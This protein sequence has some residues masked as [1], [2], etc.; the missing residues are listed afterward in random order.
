MPVSKL[1]D[2]EETPQHKGAIGRTLSCVSCGL[3][4]HAISPRMPPH[5]AGAKKLMLIG[6]GPG[7]TED[8]LGKP[9]QGKAGRT[10]RD[11][12]SDLGVKVDTDCVGLNAVNCRPPGNRAPTPHES[13]CCRARIVSPALVEHRPRVVLLLG[14][15]AVA[16]VIGSIYPDADER[17]GKWRGMTIPAPELGCW[18]CPTFHPSYVLREDRRPEI[19]TIWEQDLREAVSRLRVQVPPVENLHDCVTILRTDDEVVEALAR[20]RRRGSPASFDYETTGLRALV[21]ELVCASFAQSEARAY[22]FM[23]TGSERVRSAWRDFLADPSVGKISHNLKF[24]DEWSHEHFDLPDQINWAWDSMQAAHILDNR[25]GINGLKHQMFVEFGIIPWDSKI[26]SYL[27]STDDRDIRAP[28]RIREFIEMYGEDECLYYCGIDSLT[29]LRLA[30]R[31]Q[32]R[33][34]GD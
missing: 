24:E 34:T 13:A 9:W 4:K 30:T 8:R 11:A 20:V 6:E 15:S 22:A 19:A 12:L 29:A 3:F 2:L 7:E 26:S 32:K 16:S 27:K 18:I 10:L 28:N 23:F 21:H 25:P 14:G 1:F 31:Q 5:G 33:M 17:I